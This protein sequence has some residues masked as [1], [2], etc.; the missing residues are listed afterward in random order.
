MICVKATAY[1]C[2]RKRTA[3]V[4]QRPYVDDTEG[5]SHTVMLGH[6]QVLALLDKMPIELEQGLIVVAAVRVVVE[7]P[8]FAD[9]REASAFVDAPWREPAYNAAGFVG[10][11]FFVV[12]RSVLVERSYKFVAVS[13]MALRELLGAGKF[14]SYSVERHLIFSLV[15]HENGNTGAR[16]HVTRDAAEDEF[17]KLAVSVPTDHQQSGVSSLCCVEQG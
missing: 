6:G 10:E 14:D 15:G 8:A 4:R 13:R 17:A 1:S 9:M 2:G 12:Q 7:V 5:A 11:P 16:E 3:S